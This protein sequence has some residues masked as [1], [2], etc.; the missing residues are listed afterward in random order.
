M[1]LQPQLAEVAFPRMGAVP[2]RLS[3]SRR[4]I[5]EPRDV[6]LAVNAAV[7]DN[8]SQAH[9][10]S[11]APRPSVAGPRIR[12]LRTVPGRLDELLA[13]ILT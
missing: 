3:R 5:S 11:G 10:E 2:G 4:V 8:R 9:V 7:T 6:S 1:N 13:T 12:L